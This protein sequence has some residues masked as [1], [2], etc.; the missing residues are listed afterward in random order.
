MIK[1]RTIS[2]LLEIYVLPEIEKRIENGKIKR[3]D[4]PL[5]VNQFMAN[6][7]EIA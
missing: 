7:K 6:P 2:H 5:E 1:F 3:S 4:L